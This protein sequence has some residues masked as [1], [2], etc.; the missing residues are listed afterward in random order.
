MPDSTRG[1][2]DAHQA[3]S[4]AS[5]KSLCCNAPVV[6]TR[7]QNGEL[8]QCFECRKNLAFGSI[9]GIRRVPKENDDVRRSR[10]RELEEEE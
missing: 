10:P 4:A 9:G 5:G 1:K 3:G 2:A 7:D 8:L 6:L